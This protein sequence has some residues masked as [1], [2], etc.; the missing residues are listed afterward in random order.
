MNMRVASN[1]VLRKMS[2]LTVGELIVFGNDNQQIA[3]TLA[4]GMQNAEPLLG[5]LLSTDESHPRLLRPWGDDACVSFG[6]E[7]IIEPVFTSDVFP[8]NTSSRRS[9]WLCLTP[10]GWVMSFAVT[11]IDQFGRFGLEWWKLEDGNNAAVSPPGRNTV[12]FA[13][14]RIWESEDCRKDA[15]ARP[16]F[17]YEAL[18]PRPT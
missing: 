3:I 17:E 6:H 18:P 15:N 5:V 12:G 4:T 14:W 8:H 2:E 1:A 7:W 11:A 9:G 10:M 13:K 16:I